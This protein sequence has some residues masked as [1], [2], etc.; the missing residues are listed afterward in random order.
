MGFYK[1]NPEGEVLLV[2]QLKMEGDVE[3][4]SRF[5]PGR[6]MSREDV[7]RTILTWAELA[8]RWM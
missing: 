8:L 7:P 6:K 4:G 2:G 5:D 1:Y 3:D